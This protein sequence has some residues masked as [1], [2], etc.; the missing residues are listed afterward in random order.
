M[1]KIAIILIIAIL[2]FG[3]LG[4]TSSKRR[5]SSK[6]K[7]IEIEINKTIE[8]EKGDDLKIGEKKIEVKEI[9]CSG[10]SCNIT[11]GIDD[12]EKKIY[13]FDTIEI[14]GKTYEINLD[15]VDEKTAEITFKEYVKPEPVV[16]PTIEDTIV[17]TIDETPVVDPII[18]PEKEETPTTPENSQQLYKAHSAN[19]SINGIS[20]NY[21]EGESFQ[22]IGTD[23]DIYTVTFL[24]A[25]ETFG[26]VEASFSANNN[27]TNIDIGIYGI[28]EGSIIKGDVKFAD[29]V[30]FEKIFKEDTAAE[31]TPIETPPVEPV[32]ITSDIPEQE[33]IDFEKEI[34]DSLNEMKIIAKDEYIF[35]TTDYI[36]IPIKAYDPNGNNLTMNILEGKNFISTDNSD[37]ERTYSVQL[38]DKKNG[39]I[40]LHPGSIIKHNSQPYRIR[41]E[42]NYYPR[43]YL[44]IYNKEIDCYLLDL[45]GKDLTKETK[46]L[47]DND[48]VVTAEDVN[49]STICRQ[50][51]KIMRLACYRTDMPYGIAKG[52]TTYYLPYANFSEHPVVF[53]MLANINNYSE[54]LD[55]TQQVHIDNFK[56]EGFFDCVA[57]YYRL[58]PDVV[59]DLL[60]KGASD[61]FYLAYQIEKIDLDPIDEDNKELAVTSDNVGIINSWD[62]ELFDIE[63]G[64]Y[65]YKI[66]VTDG[67]NKIEKE[68]R[69]LVI[70]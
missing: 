5:S 10:Y 62:I 31:T 16:M 26:V 25:V 63:T 40:I 23:E 59:E 33:K 70:N 53:K 57:T 17:E 37:T 65:D 38:A 68:I 43:D 56:D 45:E 39:K 21:N 66:E 18:E 48:K 34:K 46:I 67:I 15:K 61:D 60:S 7:T 4:T 55:T 1:K 41:M 30:I 19:V 22:V 9:D 3:C 54:Y 2:F 29:E 35:K 49:G 11:L 13:N 20:K 47:E 69:V 27:R 28:K 51:P 24:G 36:S 50:Y 44:F 32:T 6:S 12:E 64:E 42:N 8:I 14:D 58:N 52:Q